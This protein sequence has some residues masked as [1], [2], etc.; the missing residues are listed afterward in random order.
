MDHQDLRD[1]LLLIARDRLRNKAGAY[2]R[3]QHAIET[4]I[5]GSSL[6]AAAQLS[7]PV[8]LEIAERMGSPE[9]TQRIQE[10]LTRVVDDWAHT[11]IIPVGSVEPLP[12][13]RAKT[14]DKTATPG[15]A[16]LNSRPAESEAWKAKAQERARAII[17]RQRAKDLYPSQAD[18]ADEIAREFRVA[19][20]LGAGGKPLTGAYIKRHALAGISSAQVKQMSTS[21]RRG[22]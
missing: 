18:I 6:V 12:P 8:A 22:K 14:L 9:A 2:R 20:V 1:R 5:Q 19:G 17:K 7:M 16:M 4:T 13:L 11:Q 15:R 3:F 10:H 21:T